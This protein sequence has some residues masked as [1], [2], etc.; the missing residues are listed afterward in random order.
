MLTGASV[1][2]SACDGHHG[3]RYQEARLVDSN[4]AHAARRPHVGE[5]FVEDLGQVVGI[6]GTYEQ[7]VDHDGIAQPGSGG[8]QDGLAVEQGLAGLLLDRGAPN[9]PVVTSIPVVPA[10]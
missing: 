2:G 3:D 4:L 6:L 8:A 9:S 5:E 1:T 7:G 10:T